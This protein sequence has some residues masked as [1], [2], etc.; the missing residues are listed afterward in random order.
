MKSEGRVLWDEVVALWE[1]EVGKLV[2]GWPPAFR[3][4]RLTRGCSGGC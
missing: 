3:L 2:A 1:G 4:E